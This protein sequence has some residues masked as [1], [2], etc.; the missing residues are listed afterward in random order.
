MISNLVKMKNKSSTKSKQLINE[1]RQI[2]KDRKQQ[3][4]LKNSSKYYSVDECMN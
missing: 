2:K 3:R 1:L 4:E